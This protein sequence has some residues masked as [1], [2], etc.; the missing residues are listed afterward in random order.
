MPNTYLSGVL[1][2]MLSLNEQAESEANTNCVGIHKHSKL[3]TKERSMLK[4]MVVH[5]IFQNV[6]CMQLLLYSQP[7]IFSITFYSVTS[8]IQLLYTVV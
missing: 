3:E 4:I 1:S 7:S 6:L 8:C 5:A 2:I